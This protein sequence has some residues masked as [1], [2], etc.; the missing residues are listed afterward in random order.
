MQQP[1]LAPVDYHSVKNNKTVLTN[2]MAYGIW[3]F[4]VAFIIPILCR[5]NPIHIIDTNV[6]KIH[7]NIVFQST[8][9]P[10]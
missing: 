8:L 1:V 7:S 6:F 3:K 5:I 4:N 10:S 2:T 9:K